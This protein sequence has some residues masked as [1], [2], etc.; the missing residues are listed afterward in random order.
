MWFSRIF[1]VSEFLFRV[2]LCALFGARVRKT[3]M[4]DNRIY[5]TVNIPAFCRVIT[6]PSADC[7]DFNLAKGVEVYFRRD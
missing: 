7:V 6:E 2:I 4:A 3:L 5:R 1:K